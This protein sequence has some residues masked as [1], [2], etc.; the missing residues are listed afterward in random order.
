MQESLIAIREAI[1]AAGEEGKPKLMYIS[2][3]C[4]HP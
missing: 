1:A 4:S 2:R 3:M